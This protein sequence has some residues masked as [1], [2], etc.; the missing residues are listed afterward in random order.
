MKVQNMQG[1]AG[2]PVKNQFLVTLDDGTEVF[3]SYNSVIAKRQGG[4]V[5]LD[6]TKWDYSVTTGKYRNAFLGETK[7]ETAAKI[8]A[9]VYALENLNE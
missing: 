7:K 5:T 1:N 2:Q 3:Q 8:A 9:G 4:K 6:A